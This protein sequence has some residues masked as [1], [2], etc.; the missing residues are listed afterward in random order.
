MVGKSCRLVKKKRTDVLILTTA[1]LLNLR[2]F[3]Y[4]NF[5][6]DILCKHS[7]PVHLP[8][9]LQDIQYSAKRLSYLCLISH[10]ILC[11]KHKYKGMTT[12]QIVYTEYVHVQLLVMTE[13]LHDLNFSDFLLIKLYQQFNLHCIN[14]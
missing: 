6:L 7:P 4:I 5:L 13:E 14:F 9:C 10:E 12:L 11:D 8:P 2:M 3:M 1:V